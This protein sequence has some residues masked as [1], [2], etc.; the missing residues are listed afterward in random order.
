MRYQTVVVAAA[1][2]RLATSFPHMAM[3][4]SERRALLGARADGPASGVPI[5]D[6]AQVAG[7]FDA[8]LQYVSN[9][10]DHAFVPPG[11][12]DQRGPCPG[13]IWR[14][15]DTKRSTDTASTGLN[16]MANHVWLNP[17]CYLCSTI[18]A[19]AELPPP[20]WRSHYSSRIKTHLN[21][22]ND[23]TEG[24]NSLM[25][26]SKYSEWALISQDF[27]QSTGLLRMEI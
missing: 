23:L 8:E 5:P 18:N 6:P 13:K 4:A 7:T 19:E 12:G 21:K 10:G 16:A 14:Y 1:T 17:Q 9:T 3:P 24:S 2:V 15:L 27:S 25:E 26:L 22:T 20:Q 11:A